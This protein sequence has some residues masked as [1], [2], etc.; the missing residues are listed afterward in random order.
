MRH[1]PERRSGEETR[2][3]TS[4]P[5]TQPPE[6][7][8]KAEHEMT[9]RTPRT[10]TRHGL[11]P[12]DTVRSQG[13]WLPT[14]RGQEGSRAKSRGAAASGENRGTVPPLHIPEATYFTGLGV[15][16]PEPK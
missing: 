14:L 4:D 7:Q 3:L 8:G 2:C 1:G 11:P 5:S 16:T 9:S 12:P 15:F 10:Q 6:A 13:A